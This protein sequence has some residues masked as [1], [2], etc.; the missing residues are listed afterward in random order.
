MPLDQAIR[1]ALTP[2]M[3]WRIPKRSDIAP[4]PSDTTR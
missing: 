1:F 2:H 4:E 3:D